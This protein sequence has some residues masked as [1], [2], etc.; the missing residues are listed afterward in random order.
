MICLLSA[1]LTENKILFIS[2]SYTLL[3]SATQ[4]ML[5]LMYPLQFRYVRLQRFGKRQSSEPITAELLYLPSVCL[6]LCLNC[7]YVFLAA[8]STCIPVHCYIFLSA[9]YIPD[10][11]Y[12]YPLAACVYIYLHLVLSC[13]SIG[14]AASISVYCCYVFPSAV[15]IAD[16]RT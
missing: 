11:C 15:S 10:H 16:G 2:S 5:A 7:C 13:F 6:H 9:L 1:V 12:V 14:S 8:M 4:A 3:T